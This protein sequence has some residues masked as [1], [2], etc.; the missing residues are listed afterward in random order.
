MARR[1]KNFHNADVVVVVPVLVSTFV[2]CGGCPLPA[3]RSPITFRSETRRSLSSGVGS[4]IAFGASAGMSVRAPTGSREIP[5]RTAKADSEGKSPALE[6]LSRERGP[7][8]DFR[9]PSLKAY[10]YH[11]TA[12]FLHGMMNRYVKHGRF[13]INCCTQRVEGLAGQIP[14]PHS[15]SALLSQQNCHFSPKPRQSRVW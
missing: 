11:V 15:E 12:E 13:L 10:T 7:E 3:A 4:M 2:S 6:P 9:D 8:R 5:A 1:K 14:I